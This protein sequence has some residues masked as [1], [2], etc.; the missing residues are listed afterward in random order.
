[1]THATD[2]TAGFDPEALEREMATE[3]FECPDCGTR[4]PVTAG[5]LHLIHEGAVTVCCAPK[6]TAPAPGPV[7]PKELQVMP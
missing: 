1:M 4:Q 5:T 3:V 6:V 2:A 7:M